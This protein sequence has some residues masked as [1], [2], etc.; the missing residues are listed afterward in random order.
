MNEPLPVIVRST[1]RRGKPFQFPSITRD[2]GA[3]GLC[4]VAP[5]PL[6]PGEKIN[7]HIRFAVPGSNPAQA[8]AASA[9][10]VVSRT[11]NRP[12][13]TCVFAASFLTR[14]AH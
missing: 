12:D 4:A 6:L 5:G 11:E 9:R 2:I 1:N 13:G 7:L 3:G 8:P 10:A 14:R